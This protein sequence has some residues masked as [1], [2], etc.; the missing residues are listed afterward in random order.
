MDST[1]KDEKTT[2]AKILLPVRVSPVKVE[3]PISATSERQ[4]IKVGSVVLV[5]NEKPL[6]GQPKFVP[7]RVISPEKES[8]KV[9][10]LT[11]SNTSIRNEVGKGLEQKKVQ[12]SNKRFHDHLRKQFL[13][14]KEHQLAQKRAGK[15]VSVLTPVGQVVVSTQF[16]G[17]KRERE[18]RLKAFSI[19]GAALMSEALDI[20]GADF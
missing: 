2:S 7:A 11:H 14:A 20:L 15:G 19:D 18:G 17:K 3:P 13:S 9:P 5:H 1:K 10:K 12:E 8:V 4:D 16:I 6:K